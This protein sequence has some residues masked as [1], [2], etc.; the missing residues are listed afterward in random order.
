MN[1][2]ICF[3]LCLL[4]MAVVLLSGAVRVSGQGPNQ[5]GAP[6]NGAAFTSSSQPPA[7][8]I[9][10]QGRLVYGDQPFTGTIHITFR[11]YDQ[12]SG[13][14]A[15]WVETQTVVVQ[16]GLFSVMLGSVSS[17]TFEVVT[18]ENQLWLG[19]QPEGAVEL[20][21]R[22]LL[23]AAPYAYSLLPGSTIYDKNPA[24]GWYGYTFNVVSDNYSALYASSHKPDGIGITGK[25]IDNSGT[26]VSGETSGEGGVGVYGVNSNA[27]NSYTDFGVMGEIISGNGVAVEGKK[28]GG[29]GVAVEGSNTGATGSGVVGTSTNFV[30]VWAVSTNGDGVYAQTHRS[31]KNYGIYTP[32]N[33]YSS[34]YHLSGAIMQI[35]QNSGSQ[36]LEAGDVVAFSGVGQTLKNGGV[37]IQ[38]EQATDAS[39]TA[40]AGVV[41]ERYNP[42][43]LNETRSPEG[44]PDGAIHDVLLSGAAGP[45]DYVLVVVQGLAQ[46]K[47]SAVSGTVKTGDLLSTSASKGAAGRAAE[48]NVDGAQFTLP[49]TVFAKA[50]QPVESGSQMIYVYVTLK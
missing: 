31:D 3:L 42:A 40:V 6:P 41:Y 35:M 8:Q 2:R 23:G 14:T 28:A 5:P 30:G 45:G 34:N 27:V 36:P 46:V 20:S 10:Y 9:S 29:S 19:V 32:D 16:S 33:I 13:G 26:G 50:L 12:A 7:G 39:S 18:F 4:C 44:S 37:T 43:V 22:Q 49:G 21:P 15:F 38:V 1:K 47:V 25:A 48:V 17:L 11:L 24:S